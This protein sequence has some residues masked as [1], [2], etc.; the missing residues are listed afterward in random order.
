MQLRSSDVISASEQG[1][2][3]NHSRGTPHL[4]TLC[5][6]ALHSCCIFSQKWMQ[7]PLPAK[8]LQVALVQCAGTKLA[9]SLRDACIYFKQREVRYYNQRTDCK[10]VGRTCRLLSSCCLVTRSSSVHTYPRVSFGV[11]ISPIYK[12][13]SHI[14]LG[15]TLTASF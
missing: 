3:R 9:I 4:I 6:I 7:N 2:K 15:P 8:R 5:F 12:N 1:E 13:T 11:K 14:E 10:S